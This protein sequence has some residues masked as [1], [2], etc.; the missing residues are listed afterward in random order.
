M[1][2]SPTRLGKLFAHYELLKKVV[3]KPGEIIEFGVFKGVSFVRL[4]MIR[5]LLGIKFSKKLIGFDTFDVF[6]D[7]S[8]TQDKENLLTFIK[9]AGNTSISVEQLENVLKH[10]N[11]FQSVELIKGDILV[12]LPQYMKNHPEIK[13]SFINLDTDLYE[14]AVCILENCWDKLN[15]GGI[16]V[17]DDYRFFSGE[18]KAVDDFFKDKNVNIQCFPFAKSPSYIIK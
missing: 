1:S 15:N 3:D 13:L 5:E 11:I 8:F 4:A 16:L 18:N 7:T 10:K 17:L 9:Q 14:P 6:P 2:C 12:T